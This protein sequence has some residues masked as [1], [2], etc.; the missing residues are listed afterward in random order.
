MTK[1]R[2]MV[3]DDDKH[4]RRLIQDILTKTKRYEVIQA[5]NGEACLRKLDEEDVDLVGVPETPKL[6]LKGII[7]SVTVPD[8]RAVRVGF[9]VFVQVEGRTVLSGDLCDDLDRY[10]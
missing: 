2:I 4:T 5:S 10:R 6:F 8:A 1:K 9:A 3:V 7:E